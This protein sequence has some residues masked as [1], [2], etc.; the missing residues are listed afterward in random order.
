MPVPPPLT[1]FGSGKYS[2]GDQI[3]PGRYRATTAMEICSWYIQIGPTGYGGFGA[4]VDIEASDVAFFGGEYCGTWEPYTPIVSPGAP[5]GAGS[6]IV[7]EEIEPGRYR[8]VGPSESCYWEP[9]LGF[10]PSVGDQETTS[11]GYLGMTSIG[12]LGMTI[13]D[14]ESSYVGFLSHGCGTWSR[15][16]ARDIG[17]VREFSDGTHLIGIDIETGSYRASAYSDDCEWLRLSGFRGFGQDVITRSRTPVV[18]IDAA[19]TGFHSRGCGEWRPWTPTS[20]GDGDHRVGID[21]LPGRYRAVGASEECSWSVSSLGPEP[22][23][24]GKASDTDRAPIRLPL[25]VADIDL[26]EARFTSDGCGTWSEELTPVATLGEPFGDGTY[27]VG[28]DIAPGRYRASD[29]SASCLWLRLSDFRI[30]REYNRYGLR[31][32]RSTLGSVWGSTVLGGDISTVVDIQPG[33]AGFY[34]EGCGM[35]SDDLGPTVEPGQPFGDGTFIVG[36]EVAPG[37]YRAQ[38]PSDSCYWFRLSDFLGEYGET[39]HGWV[40]RRSDRTSIVDIDAEDA[41][42]YSSGCGTWS[43]DLSPIVTPGQPFPD[44]TYIVGVDIEP[45]R[46]RATDSTNGTEECFWLRLYDF[47]GTRG[48]Y[49]GL[50]AASRGWE[51][52]A[53]I[54]RSDVGFTSRGCGTWSSELTPVRTPGESLGDGVY[55]VGVDIGPGRY[56]AHA[57]GGSCLWARLNGFGGD[58][59]FGYDYSPDTI[60]YGEADSAI[61]DI[62]PT[63]E[64]FQTH[65][66]GD[67]TDQITPVSEPGEPFGTGTYIVGVDIAP[68]P[69]RLTLKVDRLCEWTRIGTFTGEF[70]E[71]VGSIASGR[72]LHRYESS[73]PVT[74]AI[75]PSDAGFYSR[76]GCIEWLPADTEPE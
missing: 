67:W 69:Y 22:A 5:F 66:C 14:I 15:D 47:G 52:I 8:A 49:E 37:R 42:F 9:L 59:S 53:D 40:G 13:V 58:T 45:G 28:L 73:V 76:G 43:D 33:D 71:Y 72:V 26:S 56:R 21:V 31:D 44:G 25:T 10:R 39:R 12:H 64:G 41:G 48:A 20:F 57:P 62:Q 2:V 30:F 55:I 6:F 7:G 61:V 29:P 16:L 18:H 1:S 68:G 63:D 65:N 19:D 60:A 27:I 74:V 34:S 75:L 11:V 24:S 4:I 46:Y 51:R 38:T 17:P 54:D 32:I 3:A 35:W 70:Y 36:A 50:Y 23:A